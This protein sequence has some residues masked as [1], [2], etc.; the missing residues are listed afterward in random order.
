M[1]WRGTIWK[2][3][4]DLGLPLV[5]VGLAYAEGYFRQALN[6]DG[7]QGERYPTND[8]H[9]MPVLPVVD[10]A[11]K[12]VI[13]RVAYPHGD[14]LAQL[15]KVQ[16][17]RVPLFLLDSNLEDNSP[18]DRAITGS[19][20]GGD[21]E[22]R[23]RQE[24]MLG[25]GGIHALEATGQSP[26]V[27]HMNEGHSAFLALER[28]E[29]VMRQRNVSFQVASEAN[30]AGNIFTTH[31][32]VA[33]GNDAFDP[34]LVTRYLA[35]YRAA[36]GVSE[37]DLLALGRVDPRATSAA[38]VMPVLAI[39]SADHC[40]GVSRLHGEVSRR[41]WQGTCGRS[42]R[43]TR[44]PSSRLR[45]AFTPLRG[46]R[47]R[48]VRSTR[49]VPRATVGRTFGRRRALGASSRDPR[50]RA[51]V[52][53]RASSSSSRGNTRADGCARRRKGEAP[54]AKSWSSRTRLSDPQALTIGF[55]RR[56]ATY[57]RA[58]LLFTDLE[59]VKRLLANSDRPVQLVFAGKG[60]HPQD[61]GGKELIRSLIHASRDAGLRG[62]VVFIE[63]Y[64]M[65]IARA[66]RERSRCLAQHAP[67]AA[68]SERNE[69]HEGRR[70]RSPQLERA[71][72]VVRR[73]LGRARLGGGRAIGRGEEYTDA[74]GDAREAELLYDVLEREC[75]PAFLF[76]REGTS[77]LP[78]PWIRRMKTSI[79]KLAPTYN[80]AR[81]VREYSKRF[82]VTAIK[83]SQKLAEND[84][85]GAKALTAWKN[86]VSQAW[87]AVTFGAVDLERRDEFAVGEAVRVSARVSLGSL[88]PADV[89]VE[90]P[91][92]VLRPEGTRSPRA[93][94]CGCVPSI[95]AP[96]APGTSRVRSSPTRAGRRRS[97]CAS[98]PSTRR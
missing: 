37:G 59:R 91:I 89:A 19:L 17:G 51:V 43:R 47:R 63:D 25:I 21:Q 71:R 7:W 34:G 79:A 83:L 13:I 39:R 85:A 57:K 27:C 62:R 96:T 84:L 29:R 68:R 20:Y 98:F 74:S 76:S 55:A 80:T 6:T 82:Y 14:V 26:T 66:P 8:W 22:F 4:S 97:P 56:F 32:P 3:A 87:P 36:L 11:G 60:F 93:A 53:A 95:E 18:E 77:R 44:S 28:I 33:A 78:R 30:S 35:P 41:M 50:R 64:D 5:G 10:A 92:T 42:C 24:I 67:T 73:G 54:G 12:R 16:V 81:M 86:R 70:E 15:W 38:F 48:S 49:G 58:T 9:R 23:V 46:W 94:S 52:S 45:T 72:R 69:R 2:T 88:E 1:S 90:L 65:R 61:R 31:T 75:R 40:N